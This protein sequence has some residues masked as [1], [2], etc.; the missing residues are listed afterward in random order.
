MEKIH[1][2]FIFFIALCLTGCK[3]NNE[4]ITQLEQERDSLKWIN[5]ER[6]AML[7]ELTTTLS[8]ISLC[9]DSITINEQMI[10]RGVDAEGNPLSRKE[11]RSR[12]GTLSEIITSQKERMKQLQGKITESNR[13][14]SQMNSLMTYLNESLEQK[15]IE[16]QQLRREID[17]KNIDISRLQGNVAQLQDTVAE[18]RQENE[19]QREQMSRQQDEHLRQMNEVF[20][21]IGTKDELIDKGVL[22]QTG[23]L[24]KRS[25]LDFSNINRSSLIRVDK[26]TTTSIKITGKSPK[27]L[28]ESPKSSYNLEK[29]ENGFELQIIDPEK[30]WSSNNRILVIQIK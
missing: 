3:N 16:I 20:Y 19:Q 26:R 8:D 22:T 4:R 15:D 18:V 9:L 30:F 28:S 2:L 12:L 21:I 6:Q 29:N 27:I 14:V 7:D 1:L 24:F 23:K 25:S 13:I 17:N 10:R 11:L 5:D